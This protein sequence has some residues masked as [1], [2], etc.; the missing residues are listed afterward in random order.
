MEYPYI[1][2]KDKC[3]PILPL[4]LKGSDWIEFNAYAD[5]GASYSVNNPR[6]ILYE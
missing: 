6:A 2:F 4:E 3:L 1:P 5:S